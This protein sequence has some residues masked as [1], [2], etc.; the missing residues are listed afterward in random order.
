MTGWDIDPEGVHG[1]LEAAGER[2]SDLEGWGEHYGSTLESAAAAAGTL[3]FGGGGG[4]EGDGGG[5]ES[6]AHG[7]L[8]MLT[9]RAWHKGRARPWGDRASGGGEGPG[10]GIGGTVGLS[11]ASRSRAKPSHCAYRSG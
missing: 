4:G 6:L 8:L 5:G 2:A 1:V 9:G 7:Q 10:Q 11:R 3:S